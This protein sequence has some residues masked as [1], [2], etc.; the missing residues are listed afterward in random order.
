MK[1]ALWLDQNILEF[2]TPDMNITHR[3]LEDNCQKLSSSLLQ[4]LLK[5]E[6]TST[7]WF[8]RK[9][10]VNCSTHCPCMDL[11]LRLRMLIALRRRSSQVNL[12]WLD[13]CSEVW[14]INV[15]IHLT[16]KKADTESQL[17]MAGPKFRGIDDSSKYN[18]APMKSP[19]DG[20]RLMTAP[21][22]PGIKA[23]NS[24][25]PASMGF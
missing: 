8:R 20:T 18:I 17:V 22:F 19:L 14:M 25:G 6:A 16:S 12:S 10:T 11:E 3:L 5:M 2:K 1:A 23:E 13:L 4:F 21:I 24:F 9:H 7:Q 15:N